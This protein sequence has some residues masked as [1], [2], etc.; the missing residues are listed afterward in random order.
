LANDR[1]FEVFFGDVDHQVAVAIGVQ[2]DFHGIF[3]V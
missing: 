2:G 1:F 3:G